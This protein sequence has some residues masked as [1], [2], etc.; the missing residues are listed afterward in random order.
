MIYN[1]MLPVN[2][3]RYIVS[4]CDG[5]QR[6]GAYTTVHRCGQEWFPTLSALLADQFGL[7]RSPS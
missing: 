6:W 5:C 4:Y 1:L 7:D 3:R 2:G